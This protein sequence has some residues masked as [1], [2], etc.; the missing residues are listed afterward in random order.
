MARGSAEAGFRAADAA[1]I[2]SGPPGCWRDLAAVARR[3]AGLQ[4]LFRLS[5]ASP[6]ERMPVLARRAAGLCFCSDCAGV[7][8]RIEWDCALARRFFRH[9]LDEG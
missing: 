7:R 3:L 1:G 6:P 5:G 2:E 9:H 8:E 4:A